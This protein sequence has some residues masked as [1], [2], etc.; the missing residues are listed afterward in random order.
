MLSNEIHLMC[1]F[2][3]KWQNQFNWSP[4]HP[5]LLM[6]PVSCLSPCD[7]LPQFCLVFSPLLSFQIPPLPASLVSS[8]PLIV[9]PALITFTCCVLECIFR[10]CVSSGRCQ[11][12]LFAPVHSVPAFRSKKPT[13]DCCY[14]PPPVRLSPA[15]S[16]PG[17]F[18]SADCLLVYRTLCPACPPIGTVIQPWLIS[19]L[20]CFVC[21]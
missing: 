5:R 10:S 14:R 3:T 7:F 19:E 8:F 17:L 2:C 9:C 12:I 11:F 16:L 15:W 4:V 21:K 1:T 18:A 20:V 13:S 6:L